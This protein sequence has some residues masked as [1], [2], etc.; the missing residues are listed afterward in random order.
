MKKS[1]LVLLFFLTGI[2]QSMWAQWGDVFYATT[3]EGIT[4]KFEVKNEDQKTCMLAR[5]QDTSIEGVVTIPSIAN[6][7]TV[8]DVDQVAFALCDKITKVIIPNTVTY[9]GQGAFNG[10]KSLKEVVIPHSVDRLPAN[11]FID[12]ESLESFVLPS[13]VT[14][15]ENGNI[16]GGCANLVSLSVEEGNPVYESPSNSNAIITNAGYLACGCQ[17]TVIPEGVTIIGDGAF[18]GCPFESFEIPSGIEEIREYAFAQCENLTSITIPASVNSIGGIWSEGYAFYNCY[19]LTTVISYIEEP[20]EIEESNFK[21][22]DS[23]TST[24]YFTTATLYVPA[25]TK[26]K[27]MATP[28]WNKFQSIEVIGGDPIDLNPIDGETTVNMPTEDDIDD[29]VI[30]NVYYNLKGNNGYDSTEGCIIINTTTDIETV[31]GEPGSETV[32]DYFTGL[33]FLVDGNGVI[34]LD[35]QTLGV[36]VLNV[37]VGSQEPTTISKNERGIIEVAY[38]VTE[39]TYVYVYATSA[40]VGAP[41]R[42]S[43]S[44]NCVKLWSLTVKPGATLGISHTTATSPIGEE[45]YYTLD[46]R[47]VVNPTKGVYIYK[48]KKLV[49]K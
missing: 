45:M 44:E 48:G 14:Y 9:I 15:I 19:A 21:L 24:Y 46:G 38:D 23:N 27:Y 20:F 22:Y 12:C 31:D 47:K 32:K 36:D 37:K 25:G 5:F 16:F 30:D 33:I 10:C 7:Y 1:L 18:C 3:I 40:R 6:D 42:V 17:T 34:E 4:L 41:L 35:C 8:T 39:P 2:A 26:A 11:L 43:A 49:I 29:R 28:C 13:S